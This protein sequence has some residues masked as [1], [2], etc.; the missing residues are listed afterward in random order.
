MSAGIV[1][2]LEA[3]KANMRHGGVHTSHRDSYNTE[4]WQN[5]SH[6]L[7][8]LTS[9]THI[10]DRFCRFE[11]FLHLLIEYMKSRLSRYH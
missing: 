5:R 6:L 4:W 3:V 8:E 2:T 7:R 9:V 1:F 11:L 10:E